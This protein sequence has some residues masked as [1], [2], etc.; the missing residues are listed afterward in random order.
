M[1]NHAVLEH[2]FDQR[3]NPA[4]VVAHSKIIYRSDL[5]ALKPNCVKIPLAP[6]AHGTRKGKGSTLPRFMKHGLVLLGLNWAHVLHPAQI[7]YAVHARTFS[8][9]VVTLPTP[10]MESRVTSAA[11]SCSL[12]FS[13]AAV[14]FSTTS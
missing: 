13:V 5:L 11:S 2:Q 4:L 10:T 8:V 12:I 1:G 7:M 14:S 3:H 6:R 9:S